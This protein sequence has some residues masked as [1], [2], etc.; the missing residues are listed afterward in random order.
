MRAV[1]ESRM[2]GAAESEILQ[3]MISELTQKSK[4]A[5]A[6]LS[7]LREQA[8]GKKEATKLTTHRI[9]LRNALSEIHL[10]LHL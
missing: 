8:E 6:E 2:D 4:A 3:A 7:A 10:G 9:Q 1:E 5:Q